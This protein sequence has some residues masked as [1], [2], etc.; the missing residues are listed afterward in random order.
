MNILDNMFGP[1]EQT[2]EYLYQRAATI[3]TTGNNPEEVVKLYERAVELDEKHPGALFG[4]GLENDRRGND[5]KAIELY[6]RAAA[7]FPTNLGALLNLG[8][9][10]EDHEQYLSLIHI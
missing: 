2:A 3:A 6:Q 7:V 5:D 1:I 4:L 10:Y 9:L 8:V